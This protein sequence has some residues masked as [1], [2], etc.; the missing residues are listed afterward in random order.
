M[1]KW[2][3]VRLEDVCEFINGDRGKN[4]PSTKDFIDDGIPFVNAGH[5]ANNRVSFENMNYISIDRYNKLGSG[6]LKFGDVLYCLRGSLGKKAIVNFDNGAIASSLVILRTD[7]KVLLN[8][9]LFYCLDS[10]LIYEQQVK[11]NNGSS[12]PNLSASSVKQ[13]LI[14]LPPLEIQKQIAKTLDTASELVNLRKK[15]LEELDNLVKSV[16]YD[17]FKM[18]ID[19]K[20]Y[21]KLLPEV[22]SFI[23]YRGKTPEKSDSGIPFITAK[24][25]KNNSF[26]IE[27]R[28]Y[29][30]YE[31]YESVMTRGFPKVNDVIF[32]TEAPLGNICRIPKI[33]DKFAVGQRIIVMQPFKD[34][35]KSEYLEFALATDE[36]QREMLRRSSGSTVKGI[37]SKELMQLSIPLP[38]LSIQNKFAE[39]VTK[40]EEQKALVQKAIDESQ[41][42]FDSLMSKYFD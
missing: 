14:P 6:K 2:E 28:E 12:Q 23:D 27:P 25:I 38:P 29:I 30:S 18:F 21:Y 39:I 10:K 41:C 36:F 32:T 4:Y 24:N 33:F 22:C 8:N 42:L 35:L 26:S 17:M 3:M 13:Y 1:S 15:Q 11:F 34:I 19:N 16:F 20:E 7:N 9:Y 40:I 5:L 37:R 31:T